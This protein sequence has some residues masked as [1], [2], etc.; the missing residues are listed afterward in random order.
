[1]K[2]FGHRSYLEDTW[3]KFLEVGLRSY[4][5]TLLPAEFLCLLV[6]LGDVGR[7]LRV[8]SAIDRTLHCCYGQ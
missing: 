8:S 2:H 6:G 3:C 7:L 5:G 4:S 1:M